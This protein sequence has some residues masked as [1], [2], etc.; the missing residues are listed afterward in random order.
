VELVGTGVEELPIEVIAEE[1]LGNWF[2]E[3]AV[4]MPHEMEIG[5]LCDQDLAA[6]DGLVMQRAYV[7]PLGD[8]E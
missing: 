4:I 6:F 5:S 8:Q 3:D 2:D 7:T 1:A